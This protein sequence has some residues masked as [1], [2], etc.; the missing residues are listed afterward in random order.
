MTTTVEQV[1]IEILAKNL[2]DK[3]LK[4]SQAQAEALANGVNDAGKASSTSSTLFKKFGS[5]ARFALM[6][7]VGA[8]DQMFKKFGDGSKEIAN[9]GSSISSV[10][11][12]VM[13]GGLPG[14]LMAAV[15][16]GLNALIESFTG[17]DN[18]A[19]LAAQAVKDDFA[20][21]LDESAKRI[22]ALREETAKLRA[23]AT[24][25]IYMPTSQFGT[26]EEIQKKLDAARGK[27][28][29]YGGQ[30]IGSEEAINQIADLQMMLRAVRGEEQA[31]LEKETAAKFKTATD[32]HNRALKTAAEEA[33]EFAKSIKA[34]NLHDV[35]EGVGELGSLALESSLHFEKLN[36]NL[37]DSVDE[38][39]E[40]ATHLKMLRMEQ[41]SNKRWWLQPGKQE[42]GADE[43][44]AAWAASGPAGALNTGANAL[45]AIGKIGDTGTWGAAL[46]TAIGG[47]AGTVAGE[48]IGQV[49]GDF[50]GD[51]FNA[52]IS[53]LPLGQIGGEMQKNSAA[54]GVAGV[55]GAVAMLPSPLA[56]PLL[57]V[58][59][60]AG[61]LAVGSAMLDAAQ[62][63]QAFAGITRGMDAIWQRLVDA[64]EPAVGNFYALVPVFSAVADVFIPLLGGLVAG[65]DV[66]R[67]TFEALKWLGVIVASVSGELYYMAAAI[68]GVQQWAARLVGAND[69]A[70][71]LDQVAAGYEE[72]AT[73]AM[74]TAENLRG[75][76]YEAAMEQGRAMGAATEATDQFTESLQDAITNIPSWYRVNSY[77]A[78]GRSGFPHDSFSGAQAV[79]TGPVVNM[80]FDAST[81]QEV[82]DSMEREL[83]RRGYAT[84]GARAAHAAARWSSRG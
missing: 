56:L 25:R 22:G 66:A 1:A 17:V 71:S 41:Q 45:G 55:A 74:R 67:V 62:Q 63:T 29:K 44:E 70:D 37:V 8:S 77:D 80:Y 53:A 75:M 79:G 47:P 23:E 42:I 34:A 28:A 38:V 51:A 43:W 61:A 14:G 73:G 27:T 21:A 76:T 68:I 83:G 26:E 3:A 82:V 15:S 2:A 24:G 32:E 40:W 65:S 78:G 36:T 9:I 69:L 12:G 16:V 5:D 54:L 60:G 46:G 6:E 52:I 30:I 84:D 64:L 11:R 4:E 48:I 13:M 57:P 72:M 10:L 39:D 7:V 31:R 58:A 81:P 50:I 20:K 18:A 35:W 33:R 59:L 49:V 19:K